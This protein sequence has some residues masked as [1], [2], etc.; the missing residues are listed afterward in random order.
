[1]SP[2]SLRPFL[3]RPFLSCCLMLAL[4]LLAGVAPTSVG[5]T[6]TGCPGSWEARA[7]ASVA[8]FALA[9]ADLNGTLHALGGTSGFCDAFSLNEAYDATTNTWTTRAPLPTPRFHL[10]AASL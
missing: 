7:N 9:A 1:M 5:F 8:R 4:L 6:Q 3:R 2:N 10:D